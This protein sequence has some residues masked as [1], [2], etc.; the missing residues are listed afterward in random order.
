MFAIGVINFELSSDTESLPKV[1]ALNLYAR[2]QEVLNIQS[3]FQ[4]EFLQTD[5]LPAMVKITGE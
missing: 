1:M 2:Y 5:S 4:A 3:L